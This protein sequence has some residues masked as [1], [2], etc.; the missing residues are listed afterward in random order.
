MPKKRVLIMEDD[1]ED[2]ELLRELL[3]T[4][5][6]EPGATGDGPEGLAKAERL[7][8]DLILLDIRLPGLDGFTV[9]QGL[10]ANPATA[11]IPVIVVTAL[12]EEPDPPRLC[13]GGR[14][15]RHEALPRR[16]P[17][18]RHGGSP[19]ECDP[20]G[21]AEDEG[22]REWSLS[23]LECRVRSLPRAAPGRGPAGEAPMPS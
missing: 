14:G 19:R 6:Y 9:C 13:G 8:P 4:C 15:L 18:G 17:P 12:A 16:G 7:H 10:Q 21:E 20:P 23:L 5:G 22:R 3:K 11:P 2:Q 1:A